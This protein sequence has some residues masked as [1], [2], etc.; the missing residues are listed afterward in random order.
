MRSILLHID[1]DEGLEAR[2]QAALDLARAFEGHV[3]CLQTISFDVAVP[4]DLYGSMIAELVP[5]L[6]ENADKLRDRTT[7]RL[8]SEDVSWNWVQ[9]EGSVRSQ[10]LYR[11]ALADVVVMGTHDPAGGRAPSALTGDVAVHGR[12]P[13]L[14]V[15]ESARSLGLGG[16]ALVGW[17]GSTE[18][19]NAL[20]AAVPLLARASSVVL[21]TVT[22]EPGTRDFDLPPVE[23]AE[24]LARHGIG[25]EM[26]ELPLRDD[27]A[28]RTLA[29]AAAARTASLLVVGAYGHARAIE[30]LFGGVTRDLFGDPPVPVFASH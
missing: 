19:A 20:R 7:A 24:Y 4:G 17:N 3:T 26:V 1:H 30:T 2:L 29:L 25:C 23:G 28:A 10:L 21:A 12:T 15:P 27:S 16:P 5:V 8:D 9:E 22:G 6:R 11:E 18:A 13:V 14:V